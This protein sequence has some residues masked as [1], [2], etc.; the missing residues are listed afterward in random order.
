MWYIVRAISGTYRI[1]KWE[2]VIC[3]TCFVFRFRSYHTRCP[4]RP[5][6]DYQVVWWCYVEPVSFAERMD[7]G[8]WTFGHELG[9][10]LVV[11][12]LLTFF[13]L[14]WYIK[15]K[16]IVLL[17][18]FV[19][20]WRHLCWQRTIAAGKLTEKVL[21]LFLATDCE[22]IALLVQLLNIKQP[23]VPVLPTSMLFISLSLSIWLSCDLCQ[24]ILVFDTLSSWL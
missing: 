19:N 16:V 7:G 24:K 22:E 6:F 8:L 21:K 4:M 11:V 5:M 17:L 20:L 13:L 2:E 1:G 15:L 18:Y 3:T 23:L 12:I 9:F 10:R 14:L